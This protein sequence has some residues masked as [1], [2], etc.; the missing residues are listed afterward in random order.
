M[1]RAKPIILPISISLFTPA[2]IPNATKRPKTKIISI[3]FRYSSAV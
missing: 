3:Y 2:T 1:A